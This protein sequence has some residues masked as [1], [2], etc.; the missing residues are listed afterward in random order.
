MKVPIR[1]G[2]AVAPSKTPL[3]Y[4]DVQASPGAFGSHIAAAMGDLG[5]TISVFADKIEEN[6]AKETQLKANGALTQFQVQQ[7][8]VLAE[9]NRDAGPFGR[10]DQA[11][12]DQ[13]MTAADA[14]LATA[15]DNR[16][17]QYMQN[18]LLTVYGNNQIAAQGAERN[19]NTAAISETLNT[20]FE[21][22]YNIVLG[23]PT[24][25]EAQ[26]AQL[27]ASLSG[28]AG[29]LPNA[30]INTRVREYLQGMT[31]AAMRARIRDDPETVLYELLHGTAQGH[32]DASLMHAES[33]GNPSLVNQFGYAGLFQFGAPQLQTLG[34][35]TPGTGEGMAAWSDTGADAAGKWS[36]TFNIPGFPQVRSLRDFLGNPEAQQAAF[37]VHTT[38]M[39]NIIDGNGWDR[40]IGTTVRGVNITRQGLR[41]MIHLGGPGGARGF[42]NGTGNAADA[43]GT[44]MADYAAMGQGVV[45]ENGGVQAILTPQQTL[46]L[47]NEAEAGIAANA[48]AAAAARTVQNQQLDEMLK[49]ANTEVTHGYIPTEQI[50]MARA[51][52]IQVGGTEGAAALT[53]LDFLE[54]MGEVGTRFT[55]AG[56][57]QRSEVL[58]AMDERRRNGA[59]TPEE[60]RVHDFFLDLDESIRT[61]GKTD[62]YGL[63]TQYGV[64]QDPVSLNFQQANVRDNLVLREAQAE[65]IKIH[66]GPEASVMTPAEMTQLRTVLDGPDSNL[67]YAVM[68]QF[69]QSPLMTNEVI[70]ALTDENT[71]ASR[72]LAVAFD[73]AA[74]GRADEAITLIRGRA[75][76]AAGVPLPDRAEWMTPFGEYVGEAFAGMRPEAQAAFRDAA[77]TYYVGAHVTELQAGGVFN[78]EDFKE[79]IK[80]VMPGQVVSFNGGDIITPSPEIDR[81]QF[82]QGIIALENNPNWWQFASWANPLTGELTRLSGPPSYPTGAPVDVRDITDRGTLSSFGQGLYQGRTRGNVIIKDGQVLVFDLRAGVEALAGDNPIPLPPRDLGDGMIN[83][84]ETG[85]NFAAPPA[86]MA[87]A[88]AALGLTPEQISAAANEGTDPAAQGLGGVEPVEDLTTQLVTGANEAL[89][90]PAARN[91]QQFTNIAEWTLEDVQKFQTET[92]V[93]NDQLV[94]LFSQ[95][96]GFSEIM[97]R[98]LLGNLGVDLTRADDKR[99]QRDGKTAGNKL[100]TEGRRKSENSW[101][102]AGE[103]SPVQSNGIALSDQEYVTQVQRAFGQLLESTP[104]GGRITMT[105]NGRRRFFV[106][107]TSGEH[108]LNT[109]M[110]AA[111]DDG[112]RPIPRIVGF[113]EVADPAGA[114]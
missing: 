18:Q 14:L 19:R 23:D 44:T 5:E 48:R 71:M 61:D 37:A 21:T 110:Y 55:Q 76:I 36:G 6:K 102:D 84:T 68:A 99:M 73:L 58:N 41:N 39:D 9:M 85:P 16:T 7:E 90:A 51:L 91:P 88:G 108:P 42:L 87:Q 13:F 114:N 80:A 113:T 29:V 27:S 1:T 93:T 70:K 64:I 98:S 35:Y 107:D 83:R 11:Y 32:A 101:V 96:Y 4:L 2:A 22:A 40:Y 66:F 78:A 25:L 89:A 104:I 20:Q 105:I 67:A 3:G 86:P 10:I 15:P 33:G 63:A 74:S 81:T 49:A 92:M 45:A 69:A 38:W 46:T 75:A 43:N 47:I 8:R 65:Q 106:R 62:G 97:I 112:T 50:D 60:I 94:T 72:N 59:L 28:S 95:K 77:I 53:E 24:Q 54:R 12:H 34:L 30:E 31:E 111:R 26:V 52:A 109:G 79:A 103:I 82:L 17:R 100:N 56:S 57:L